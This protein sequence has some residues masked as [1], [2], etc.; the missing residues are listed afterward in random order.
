MG[1]SVCWDGRFEHRTGIKDWLNGRFPQQ[2]VRHGIS[3]THTTP[4]RR[5]SSPSKSSSPLWLWS[6]CEWD[7]CSCRLTWYLTWIRMTGPCQLPLH[8]NHKT[9]TCRAAL[10]SET[11]FY[12]PL[13]NLN[14]CK[15]AALRAPFGM[16]DP[17]P[18]MFVDVD[19]NIHPIIEPEVVLLY[20]LY[21]AV[22]GVETVVTN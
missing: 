14:Y 13:R 7:Y 12:S 8:H 18:G 9:R 6:P 4:R 5:C 1:G 21:S 15:Q 17:L 11:S 16:P 20:L 3:Y 19:S 22:L 10:P 2:P